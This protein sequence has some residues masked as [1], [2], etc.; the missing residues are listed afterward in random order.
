MSTFVVM[1]ALFQNVLA[2]F[3]FWEH[4]FAPIIVG[5]TL[6]P[7][8]YFIGRKQGAQGKKAGFAEVATTVKLDN[9][10][11]KVEYED[12]DDR[13]NTIQRTANLKFKQFGSR[14][15]GEGSDGEGREW[16]VEGAAAERRVCYIYRDTKSNR[17][18]FGSDL[19]EMDNTGNRM[20]GLWI[21]WSP[22]FNTLEP[23][24]LTL[25]KLKG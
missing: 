2:E 20:T 13:G 1:D 6:A 8:S 19:L 22:Q 5:I 25:T 16:I 9:T 10:K 21:G 17:L 7:L 15:V 4:I 14:I 24:P 11:W 3:D 23:R 12:I 18:S